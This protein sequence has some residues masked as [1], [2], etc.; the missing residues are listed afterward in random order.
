M[1]VGVAHIGIVAPAFP[2]HL[3]AL[4]ALADRLRACGH[5]VSFLLPEYCRRWVGPEHGLIPVDREH[6]LPLSVEAMIA[7]ASNPR[8]PLRFKRMLDDV[9]RMTD[10]LCARLPDIIGAAGI[11]ALL[12]DQMETAGALV[13]R[14]M[15]LPYLS[16]ACALPLDRDPALP[17]PFLGWAFDASEQG[18]KRNQGGYR[19]SELLM[20]RHR[21]I[22][23]QW[24]ERFGVDARA[25][26]ACLSPLGT[27]A[28]LHEA[29]D[30]PRAHPAPSLHR[31]GPFRSAA[32]E[33]AVCQA[34]TN[35]P[36]DVFASLGTLQG[37][38]FSVFLN[39][40]R[41]CRRIH[42]TLLITHCGQLDDRQCA[43]LT[44]EGAEVVA[45]VDQREVMTTARVVVTHGGLNTV[46]DAL[47][48]GVPMLVLPIAFD[49]PGVAAR[50]VYHGIGL[51]APF[52]ARPKALAKRL[53][54]LL[55]EPGFS[56]AMAKVM[57][58]GEHRQGAS[59][60]CELIEA[61][62]LRQVHET[63]SVYSGLEARSSEVRS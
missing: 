27:V 56:A 39:L 33:R 49:Q 1:G 59:R 20:R 44:R 32:P 45:N 54:R 7:R 14:S 26:E 6:P 12:V 23:S 58:R 9:A 62:L 31:V 42:R 63:R 60:A 50:V 3:A 30:F 21:R 4:C 16:V 17:P 37:W 38:R 46:M 57:S 11:D 48:A 24:A 29:L 22:L 25:M 15:N 8:G 53:S 18:M 52:R 10:V 55:D 40:A 2:S 41:A 47:D 19:V 35:T 34:R 51:S 28:Q 61:I 43:R 5:R 36:V 13:A